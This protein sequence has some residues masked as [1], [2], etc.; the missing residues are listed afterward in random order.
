[1]DQRRYAIVGT[2]ARAEM[3]ARAMVGPH[4]DRCA[5]VAL[6]DSNPARYQP[7][8]VSLVVEVLSDGSVRTDTIM[9]PVEYAEVGIPHYWIVDLRP[10]VTLTTYRLI[11]QDYENFGEHTGTSTLDLDGTSITLDLTALTTSRAQR[12]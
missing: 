10:P 11:G 5:L 12:P 8:E 2:G 9:K 6:A 3:F 7:R 4:A 1:M